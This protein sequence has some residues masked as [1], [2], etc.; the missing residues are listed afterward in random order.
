[1]RDELLAG[2]RESI[3]MEKR[4]VRKG[5]EIIWVR[6]SVSATHA[7]GGLI[8]TLIV[9]AEDITEARKSQ[10]GLA[11][12]RT[13]IDRSPD[14]IEVL[15]PRTG[16]FLDVNETG[17]RRLGYSREEL[18][19]MNASSVDNGEVPLSW[20]AAVEAIKKNDSV[21]LESRH[22]R[23]D[24]STFPVEIYTRYIDLNQGYV[25][26]MVRDIT[27]RKKTEARF[28]LLVDSN[29]QGVFF[30]NTKGE[31]HEANDAFLNLVAY[32]RQD[33]KDGLINWVTLT[34][35]EYVYLDQ[36]A[37]GEM[38]AQSHCTP[39]EKEFTRKDGSRVPILLGAATFGDNPE[40]GVCFTL[41]LSD[42][43]KAEL[44]VRFNEQRYRSLVEA[45]TAIVWDTPASGEFI[46]EQPGWTAFTGQSFDELRGWGWLNAIHPEDRAETERVW[47]A[48]LASRSRYDVEHRLRRPDK[49]YCNMVVRAVPILG[50]NGTIR[51]WIGIHTDITERKK[52][53]HQF[54]RAQRMES[55]GTL[56]GGVA[57][58]LNNILAPI[59]MS[60]QILKLSS[61]DSETT[62][63]LKTIETSA[64]RGADSVRQ[65]LSFAR[66]LE[67]QRIEVQ[68]KHLLDEIENIITGTFSK[69]IQVE[70]SV[71]EDVWTIE[72]D[73]TQIHQILLNLCVNARDA[74]PNGGTLAV[75]VENCVLDENYSAMNLQAKPG[76]YVLISVTDSGTGMSQRI[77]EKIFEPFFTTKELSKGTGLGLSTLMAIVK[78]H[79]GLINVYSELGKGS[80]FK[81]YLPA[82]ENSSN[83]PVEHDISLLPRGNGQTV[84]VIDDEA[85]ILTI[86]GQT[87]KAFG[88]KSLTAV[89]GAQ[90]VAVYAQNVNEIAVV[91]T[92]MNMPIMNG[93]T[94]I[95]ALLRI[96]PMVK[97]IAASGLNVTGDEGKLAEMGVI[98]SLTKPYTAETLLSALHQVL[99]S[100]SDAVSN[101]M[102][103]S[104]I[105]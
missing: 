54:L 69:N 7:V 48:A 95:R 102:N 44:E 8:D 60:I 13:L 38:A 98:Y 84:L 52:L 56:A 74:M 6:A 85:S 46:V 91:I 72:G 51:Q 88:Y 29:A 3:V 79:E 27:E 68:P 45:T 40:E 17:C 34:P 37:L 12:F 99:Q 82:M 57:H 22:L 35:P 41:D 97:I 24:G 96:N 62:D 9:M 71:P 89:D 39:F 28:R 32:S 25:V 33:L 55:I 100:P 86:T 80:T 42:R 64:K 30:W 19:S 104:E 50:D 92:D 5:G 67:S 2:L 43:K 15:D 70:F 53:E 26:A 49:S 87:L 36:I 58:D 101:R 76:R 14:A 11:L 61:T 31:I 21:L 4:Y 20:P 66:G 16:Q 103:A 23:K 94:T 63:I 65:V 83:T 81:V 73:P 18:L 1:M 93:M 90:G 75:S 59:L 77:M 105:S 10:E 78:S 47:S